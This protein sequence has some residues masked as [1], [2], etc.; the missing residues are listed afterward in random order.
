MT[1]TPQTLA[2][3]RAQLANLHVA[4]ANATMAAEMRNSVLTKP[5]GALGQLETIAIWLAGWHGTAKPR[6]ERPQVTIFAGNHGVV[7][8]GVSAFPA[9]VTVQ[10]VANFRLGGAAI[11]QLAQCFGAAMESRNW[12]WTAPPAT[13]P[14]ARRCP[15]RTL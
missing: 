15:R 9:E 7:A 14:K 11:N 3:F 10:M 6:I 8:Q 4:H 12:S 13:S 1:D 5:P 2:E